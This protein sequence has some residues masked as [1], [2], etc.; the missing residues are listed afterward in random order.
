LDSRKILCA[1]QDRSDDHEIVMTAAFGKVEELRL[2]AGEG[3]LR[4]G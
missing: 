4:E 3:R 1:A 2:K